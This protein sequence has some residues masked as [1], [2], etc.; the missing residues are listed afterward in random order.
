MVVLK[1]HEHAIHFILWIR[2]CLR[3]VMLWCSLLQISMHSALGYIQPP[4]FDASLPQLFFVWI[5]KTLELV[6]LKIII[7]K[8]CLLNTAT[9][10]NSTKSSILRNF[11]NQ[12][13]IFVFS[14]LH[15]HLKI[16]AGCLYFYLENWDIS[17]LLI[18]PGL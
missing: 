4:L 2:I 8:S 7:L 11:F 9:N 5:K 13:R 12:T 18:K 1:Y 14:I 17:P 6:D 15:Q 3:F 10:F 16:F